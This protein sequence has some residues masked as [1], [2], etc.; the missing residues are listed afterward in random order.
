MCRVAASRDM[1]TPLKLLLPVVF[2]LA[3]V[4]SAAAQTPPAPAPA[5]LTP[6]QLSEGFK[7]AFLLLS[8]QALPAGTIKMPVPNVITQNKDKI[9][10]PE[11][12]A[13]L[14]KFTNALND[15]IGKLQPS[16]LQS[17]QKALR[18]LK[19]DDVK[20]LM[21]GKADAGT[22]FL[23]TKFASALRDEL[24]PLVKRT[25]A[26]YDAGTKGQALLKAINPNG[27]V[28]GGNLMLIELDDS[29]TREIVTQAFK[30]IGQKETAARKDP[31]LLKAT[32][33]AQKVF[34]AYKK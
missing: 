28:R 15:T 32:P 13:A 24:L 14:D 25:S 7:G 16:L 23:R 4:L 1:N 20:T 6:A 3:M 29:I 34:E 27:N 33:L 2:G 19:V 31:A 21:E 22:Q 30:L 12:K 11:Q 18:D 8:S 17:F 9:V 5:A 26:A 10:T